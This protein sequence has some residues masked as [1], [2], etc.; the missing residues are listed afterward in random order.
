MTLTA[1]VV[2]SDETAAVEILSVVEQTATATST[3]TA[4]PSEETAAIE[5]VAVVEMAAMSTSTSAVV[6]SDETAAAEILSVVEQAA[7]ATSEE[8][9]AAV[10]AVINSISPLPK[11]KMERTRKRKS[12]GALLLTG[13][14]FK[15]KVL[16]QTS[17]KVSGQQKQGRPKKQV[18]V[19][20][21]KEKRKKKMTCRADKPRGRKPR[22]VEMCHSGKTA[23]TKTKAKG[24]SSRPMPKHRPKCQDEEKSDAECLM[25][26]ELYS[27]SRSGEQWIECQQCNNWCHEACTS[28]ETSRG[29]VCDFCR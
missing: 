28:G 1:G 27:E 5:N 16:E 9:A 15:Q 12:E 13:S 11:S 25:C 17:R 20:K 22:N 6:P 4:V 19:Q 18:K 3:T 10:V 8:T 7:T 23:K 14:P 21:K 24:Q 29:F 26:G 2:P